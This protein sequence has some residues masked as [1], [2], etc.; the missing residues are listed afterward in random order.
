V[1]FTAKDV[2]TEASACHCGMCRRWSGGPFIGLGVG[3]IEWHASSGLKTMK[4]SE[5]AERG[6]CAECGS[7]LFYRLTSEGEY[8]GVTSLALGTLEDQGGVTITREW[9]IDKKPEAYT[10]AGERERVTEA[11]V[12]AMF[13]QS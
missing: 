12:F 11:E 5:W 9:F 1:E 13:A 3:S 10:L 2:S 6:F 8:K 4:T 7:S